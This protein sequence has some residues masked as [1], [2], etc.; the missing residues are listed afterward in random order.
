[1]WVTFLKIIQIIVLF[2]ARFLRKSTL[3]VPEDLKRHIKA[4][5]HDELVLTPNIFNQMQQEEERNI[6]EITYANFLQ[7]DMYIDYVESSRNPHHLPSTS[8]SSEDG[9]KY[10]SRSSTLPTLHEDTELINY[11]SDISHGAVGG[12]SNA[13]MTLTKD[14]LMATQI[15]RLEINPSR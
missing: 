1:M 12:A 5:L 6:A 7:S 13:P 14:A 15:R 3:Y 8:S 4:G 10:I 11:D 9:S 2:C